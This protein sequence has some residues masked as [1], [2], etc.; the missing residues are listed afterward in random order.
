MFGTRLRGIT[1]MAAHVRFLV[2]QQLID[3]RNVHDIGRRAN[4]AEYQSRLSIDA[5]VRLQG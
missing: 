5:N 1:R 2:M 3:R 4:H